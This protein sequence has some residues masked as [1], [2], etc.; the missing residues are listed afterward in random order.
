MKANRWE[1]IMRSR[2][3]T[4]RKSDWLAGLSVIVG[5]AL[6]SH[7][8]SAQDSV[9]TVTVAKPVVRNVIDSDEFIGRFEPAEQISVR[10]RVG[11]YLQ[12]I[13]FSDGSIVNKGD[14]LFVIDQRPFVAALNE[15]A[16]ALEV[17]KS[18]LVYAQ[19]QFKR[20]DA[21]SQNG[22]QSLSVLDD[23]RRELN[24]AE[25][26]VRG[27]QAAFD[28]AQLDLDYTKI[29]A[30]ITGRID[31]KLVSAGNLVQ[32]DQT[33]LTSIV[34]LDPIDF[35]FDVDERRMLKFAKTARSRGDDLQQGGGG[36]AVKV[37]IADEDEQPFGGRLDFAENRI[38]DN[39][40][41]MRVRARFSNSQLI[42]QPGLF[43]RAEIEASGSHQAVLVPDEAIASDQSQ[44]VVYVVG[45]DGTV[46]SKPIEPGQRL[47][48]YRVIREGLTGEETIVVNGLMRLRP[49]AKVA[50]QLT[51]LPSSRDGV[52][53]K[54]A[55]KETGQ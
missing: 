23:R 1:P 46:T 16:A 5:M 34:S 38:D 2:P 15:A 44:R 11:G 36:L 52:G 51:L 40:G 14:V 54:V 7:P 19:A 22:S 39:T 55:V 26:N 21:L 37:R 9:P 30:P 6:A 4:S 45:A 24:S 49:G 12:D 43:G 10:A 18:T 35:Y 29:V 50:T 27:A 47:H 17:A 33:V 28:R 32:A 31:R 42:L 53:Q 13:L 25:A 3:Q 20:A 41:T 8:A 48:G